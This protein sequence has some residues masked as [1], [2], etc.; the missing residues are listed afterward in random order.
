MHY[1]AALS[2][3]DPHEC[4]GR[5]M[6]SSERCTSPLGR[7]SRRPSGGDAPPVEK[8]IKDYERVVDVESSDLDNI[9]TSSTMWDDLRSSMAKS[10]GVYSMRI[11]SADESREDDCVRKTT[12]VVEKAL[13]EVGITDHNSSYSS[14]NFWG[15]L[16]AVEDRRSNTSAPLGLP[17]EDPLLL[18]NTWGRVSDSLPK[19]EEREGRNEK[20][21]RRRK[22]RSRSRSKSRPEGASSDVE[23]SPIKAKMSP[24]VNDRCAVLGDNDCW[25]DLCCMKDLYEAFNSP[26]WETKTWNIPTDEMPSI[27]D[28][29]PKKTKKSSSRRLLRKIKLNDSFT[30]LEDLSSEVAN[31]QLLS[32]NWNDIFELANN[33]SEN[34]ENIPQVEDYDAGSLH[35]V[36]GEDMFIG[37]SES[38]VN[39]EDLDDDDVSV[40]SVGSSFLDLFHQAFCQRNCF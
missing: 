5:K 26:D 34:R 11:R 21:Q 7:R 22:K 30:K 17:E 4:V 18:A 40:S 33:G 25:G 6:A 10:L 32:Q 24:P 39:D 12:S 37:D 23:A 19:A 8:A 20:K 13:S 15:D 28:L 14:A 2:H 16:K 36:F 38:C 1:V 31:K 29:G 9:K 35:V 27:P 3:D